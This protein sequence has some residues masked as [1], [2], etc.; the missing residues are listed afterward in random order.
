MLIDLDIDELVDYIAKEL[1]GWTDEDDVVELYQKMYESHNY[2][3]FENG[4]IRS[5]VDNDFINNTT[6]LYPGDQAY[7]DIKALYDEYGCPNP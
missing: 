6:R 3:D 1:R 7:K 5:V 2:H 4:N